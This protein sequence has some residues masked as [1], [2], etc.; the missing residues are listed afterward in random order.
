[1]SQAKI[2]QLFQIIAALCIKMSRGCVEDDDLPFTDHKALY[3]AIDAI[4]LGDAPWECFTIRY[5]GD[6]GDHNTPKWMDQEYEIWTCNVHTMVRNLIG[7]HDFNGE[8]DYAPYR[9]FVKV[10]GSG[11]GSR[12]Y[13]DFMSGNWAWCQCVSLSI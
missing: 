5:N 12:Q 11:Q 1:M 2:D 6:Q 13:K 10:K 7:N 3:D 4:T 9:E 8:W